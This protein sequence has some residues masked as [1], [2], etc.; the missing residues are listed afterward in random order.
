M[1][2]TALSRDPARYSYYVDDA[3]YLELIADFQRIR[4]EEPTV[5]DPAER[6]RFRRLIEREARLLDRLDFAA[7]MAS[8]TDECFYWVP[9]TPNGG[10]PR[11]RDCRHVR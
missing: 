3:A 5:E 1:S 4:T 2:T 9:S 6:D 11:E 7:W 8:Y 10:D